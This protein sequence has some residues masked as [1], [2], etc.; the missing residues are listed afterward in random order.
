MCALC[1]L[2][3][4]VGRMSLKYKDLAS[5]GKVAALPCN[6]PSPPRQCLMHSPPTLHPS[7]SIS[8][9]APFGDLHIAS[10]TICLSL[11]QTESGRM[12]LKY[13]DLAAKGVKV[14]V[15]SCNPL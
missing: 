12:S 1:V 5:K 8:S 11:L 3:T 6:P 7:P 13:K 15:L 2:Q 14:A 9:A 4:E 10:N